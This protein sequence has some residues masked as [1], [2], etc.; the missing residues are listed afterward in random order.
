MSIWKIFTC[1]IYY[2]NTQKI[3]INALNILDFRS[4]SLVGGIH[5]IGGK[6]VGEISV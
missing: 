3:K 1:L 5:K 2:I 6:S 4:I